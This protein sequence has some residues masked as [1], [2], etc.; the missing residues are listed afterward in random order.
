M[1]S[2]QS[3]VRIDWRQTH[4]AGTTGIESWVVSFAS[5]DGTG[6]WTARTDMAY[7][8]LAPEPCEP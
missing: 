6:G 8:R 1:G 2:G 4:L 7:L 3:A 5:A